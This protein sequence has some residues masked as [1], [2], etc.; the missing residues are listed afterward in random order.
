MDA[1]DP[2]ISSADP[3]STS[4]NSLPLSGADNQKFD[5]I[6]KACDDHDLELLA[7]LASSEGGLIEDG[8]RRTACKFKRIAALLALVNFYQGHYCL[9]VSRAKTHGITVGLLWLHIETKNR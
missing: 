6:L 3:N 4:L 9:A 1:P 7:E 5:R 2:Q 8:A